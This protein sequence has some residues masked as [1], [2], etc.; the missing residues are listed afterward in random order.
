MEKLESNAYISV[1]LGG[2]YSITLISIT[3]FSIV[4]NIIQQKTLGMSPTSLKRY[5]I[6]IIFFPLY[7]LTLCVGLIIFKSDYYDNLTFVFWISIDLI[8]LISVQAYSILEPFYNL[9]EFKQALINKQIKKINVQNK[10]STNYMLEMSIIKELKKLN[11]YKEED[12]YF[13]I[14]DVKDIWHRYLAIITDKGIRISKEF[15][16]EL[17][18]IG[19]IIFGDDILSIL[20]SDSLAKEELVEIIISDKLNT[21]NNKLFVFV[22]DKLYD[23]Y[24][25]YKM[26]NQGFEKFN[27]LFK[28][29]LHQIFFS[30][31]YINLLLEILFDEKW[32][33]KDVEYISLYLKNIINMSKIIDY[34]EIIS[35]ENLDDMLNYILVCFKDKTKFEYKYGE[36][37]DEFI[38]SCFILIRKEENN[39]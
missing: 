39:D 32:N 35:N 21:P 20:E 18:E 14:D 23:L 7:I 9:Q 34:K 3:I 11:E 24:E 1:I 31:E 2:L 33:I 4:G 27:Q 5:Q 22:F 12:T 16:K 36:V 6:P 28:D 13:T 29:Y 17:V 38:K 19:F 30:K 10:K 8:V 37:F 26:N 15:K 25:Y